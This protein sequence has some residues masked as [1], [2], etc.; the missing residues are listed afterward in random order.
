M[1]LPVSKQLQY[2]GSGLLDRPPGHIEV[3]PI[4]LGAQPTGKSDLV[5]NRLSV[6]IF[7]IAGTGTDAQQSILPDLDQP[8][9]RRVQADNERL[10]Q[11]F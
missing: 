6:D 3:R 1:P 4:E 9:R 7:V 5:C 11:M 2:G 10:L 8:L